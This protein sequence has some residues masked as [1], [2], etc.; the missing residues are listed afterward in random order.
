M[1]E[2]LQVAVLVGSLRKAS[3]SRK[4]ASALVELAPPSFAMRPIELGDLPLYNEDLEAQVPGPWQRFRDEVRK[5]DGVLFVTAE[6]N[7]SVP[8]LLKNAID[9]GSR[10]YGK[11]A[12]SG[13]PAAVVSQSPG[14]MGG[15]GAN[16]HLRQ[17]MVF[18]DMPAMPQPEIYLSHSAKLFDEAGRLNADSTRQLLSDMMKKFEVWVRRFTP[19]GGSSA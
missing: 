4:V 16:H 10:P 15:F 12:W 1:A 8:G 18:L 19:G 6:Y 17:M 3:L 2:K 14:S 9:V 7:R 11:S 13:K 5:A